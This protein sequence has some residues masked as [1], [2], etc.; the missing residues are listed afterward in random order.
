MSRVGRPGLLMAA[1]LLVAG[2]QGDAAGPRWFPLEDGLR[3]H[4][5]VT[6]SDPL[7][8]RVVD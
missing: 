5:Q 1:A 3:W 7:G 8:A 4:Y 2:C 6:R